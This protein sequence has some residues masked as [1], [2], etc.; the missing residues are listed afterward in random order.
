MRASA[1]VK[2]TLGFLGKGGNMLTFKDVRFLSSQLNHDLRE[3]INF[4]TRKLELIEISKAEG[5]APSQG[6]M[7][8]VRAVRENCVAIIDKIR[9]LRDDVVADRIAEN[10]FLTRLDPI[11]ADANRLSTYTA[12]SA[13]IWSNPNEEQDPYVNQIRATALRFLRM[14]RALLTV[15]KM[16]DP[17]FIK[18]NF[19]NQAEVASTYIIERFALQVGRVIAEKTFQWDSSEV[20]GLA[21]QGMVLTIFQNIYENSV[22]YRSP[23]RELRIVTTFEKIDFANLCA[24]HEILSNYEYHGADLLQIVVRDNGVGIP[25]NGLKTIF[26]AYTQINSHRKGRILP[27][28]EQEQEEDKD[29]GL[30]LYTVRKMIAIHNGYVFATSDEKIGTAFYLLFPP[31]PKLHNI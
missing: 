24:K 27:G 7:D 13:S 26:D 30:G 20:T 21:D 3:P 16:S 5:K 28:L 4:I 31:D 2:N 14:L 12:K 22:K 29:V 19:R 11:V 15:A 17:N 6:Q 25:P 1:N 18:T 10:D 9:R 23:D 8:F